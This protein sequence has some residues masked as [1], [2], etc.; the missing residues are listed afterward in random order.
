MKIEPNEIEEIEDYVH[1]GFVFTN[2]CGK[3]SPQIARDI[4][5]E[6]G[7]NYT[8]S[9]VRFN[10]GGAS[11]ILLLSNYLT[12]RKIQLR[13]SQIRFESPNTWLEIIKVSKPNRVHL[14][15]RAVMLLSSLGVESHVFQELVRE[16]LAYWEKYNNDKQS[17]YHDLLVNHF[18]DGRL[19]NFQQIL[20]CKFLGRSDPFIS[21]IVTSYQ[22]YLSR[23][24]KEDCRLYIRD[25]IKVFAAVD[26]SGTLNPGEIFLQLTAPS[27]LA[28]HRRVVE[29]PCVVYR[30]SS[31]FPGD[32][33]VLNAVNYSK[34]RHYTNVLI[35][36]A[37]DMQDLPSLCSNDDSAEDNFTVIWDL[38]LLPMKTTS[39]PR[40]YKTAE[41][42]KNLKKM[43]FKEA[44]KFFTTYISRD[45]FRLLN[46]AYMAFSDRHKEGI[47]NGNCIYLSHQV[48][49]ALGRT[50]CHSFN[51]SCLSNISNYAS[52]F[53]QNWYFRNY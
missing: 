53:C 25:G 48:C 2:D 22:N 1:N 7:M 41:A 38:R 46:R 24:L 44:S 11:G 4:A 45:T 31:C 52:R 13:S 17:A 14:N 23:G 6:L 36:S 12:K 19:E 18:S 32:V 51:S 3:M 20:N 16:D 43:T 10:L 26:E 39:I 5:K 28:V 21:N 47:F 30:D 29:G 37:I 8:P 35:F 50:H 42:P 27:G 40:N 34:L 49:R 33:R 9:V 15:K